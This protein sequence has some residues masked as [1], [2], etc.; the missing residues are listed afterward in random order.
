VASRS[1]NTPRFITFLGASWAVPRGAH[2][3]IDV[4][5]QAMP[6]FWQRAARF[7]A[8]LLRSASRRAD[9]VRRVGDLDSLCAAHSSRPP[10]NPNLI[11]LLIIP[12]SACLARYLRETIV[13]ADATPL[14]DISAAVTA[15]GGIAAAWNG[16]AFTIIVGACAR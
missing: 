13:S 12:T 4:C 8:T 16:M 9:G 2:I 11:V 15:V 5:V 1:S 10:R 3:D 7:S 14:G 6:K